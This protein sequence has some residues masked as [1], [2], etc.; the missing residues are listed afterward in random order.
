MSMTHCFSNFNYA[1]DVKPHESGSLYT[2]IPLQ[3]WLLN[4]KALYTIHDPVFEKFIPD[5]YPP[6]LQLKN[7]NT[8]KTET[9]LKKI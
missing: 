9:P 4:K 1:Y 6:K 2:I 5:F 8:S 3:K 7:G